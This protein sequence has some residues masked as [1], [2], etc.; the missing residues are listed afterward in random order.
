MRL[1]EEQIKRGILHTDML[2][3]DAALRYFS[4]SFSDDR[5]IMPL[6]IEA[7]EAYGWEDAFLF[8]N[9]ASLAQTEDTLLWLIDQLNRQGRPESEK[10]I[11]HCLLLSSIISE[12]NVSLLMKHDEAILGL[13]GLPPEHREVI[14]ERLR[15]MTL[16]TEALWQELELFCQDAKHTDYPDQ[17]RVENAFRLAEAIAR[18]GDMADRVLSI[19]SKRL[20]RT[21]NDP[22]SWIQIA[23]ARIAG[24]MRLAEAAPRLAARL[25]DDSGDVMNEQ[26]QRAFVKIGGQA[27]V[28]A[29]VAA[30]GA[31]PWHFKLYASSAMEHIHCDSVVTQSLELLKSEKDEG[32][33]EHLVAAILGNFCSDGIEPARQITLRG[34]RELRGIL[35]GVAL[36]MAMPFP[37]LQKW[38]KEERE[39]GQRFKRNMENWPSAAP[40]PAANVPAFDNVV[41]PEPV[42]PIVAKEKVGRNDPC[43]CGSGKKYKKCCGKNK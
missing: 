18:D 6:A 16:D 22:M 17:A 4:Q 25:T 24:D 21:E 29:I 33:R 34:S 3:R 1:T 31:A 5:T 10:D 28:E 42:Q 30:F 15:M 8:A 13:E 20:H 36:L 7:I 2:A 40:A 11:N 32:I 23:A 12:A 38:N 27:A 14:A 37:E 26:C 35:V 41:Y 9:L 43:P 39:N 19:L